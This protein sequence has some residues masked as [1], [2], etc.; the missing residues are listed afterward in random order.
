[1]HKLGF[2]ASS[3]AGCLCIVTLNNTI[4]GNRDYCFHL[5][6]EP[7]EAQKRDLAE[8]SRTTVPNARPCEVFPA[9]RI[10]SLLTIAHR[11]TSPGEGEAENSYSLLL[12]NCML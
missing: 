8:I 9:P 7:T 5:T 6:N 3:N 1:M 2:E 10:V 11:G 4:L 12:K